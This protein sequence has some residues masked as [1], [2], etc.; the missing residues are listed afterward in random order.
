M[1]P[2]FQIIKNPKLVRTLMA[3]NSYL[4]TWDF[5]E[6]QDLPFQ[7]Q[8]CRDQSPSTDWGFLFFLSFTLISICLSNV[9]R[10]FSLLFSLSLFGFS[11]H[12]SCWFLC[13]LIQLPPAGHNSLIL[14]LSWSLET[15]MSTS[16]QQPVR[17]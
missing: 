10:G 4:G 3:T 8:G 11:S 16:P 7:R 9:G 12:L 5:N 2:S 6:G 15:E 1:F 14:A 17:S 13:R